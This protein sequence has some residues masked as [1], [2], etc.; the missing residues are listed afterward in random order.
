MTRI[1][2]IAVDDE[3]Y[4]INMIADY[5]A[6]VSYLEL[7]GTTTNAIEALNLVQSGA[8]D[9][10]F[11]DIQMPELT[12]L[13]F[14][15]ICGDKCKV[16]LTTA[17]AEYALDGFEYGVIDYLLK[18]IALDRFLRAAQKAFE[19][20]TGVK[21][22]P[23][24]QLIPA[25]AETVPTEQD[26]IFIKGDSKNKFL[27]IDHGDI[28]YIQGLKNYISI[29]TTTQRIIT[30]Q[31][32]RDIDELLPQ[33]PFYRIHKSYI[34]SIAKMRMVDGHTVYIGDQAI[35]IGESYQESFLKI[36]KD[37]T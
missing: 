3:V 15:K 26:Y 28:L 36:I 33:P 9:L 25:A 31:S 35:P 1:R 2:C 34:I 32:L 4:A 22:L 10:V 16:I 14:L 12:G 19:Q 18:P 13:Q 27:K 8:V 30:Y 5:I 17:Y 6:R 21:Q 7:V 11:L 20:F 29:F 24:K 37:R 23:A